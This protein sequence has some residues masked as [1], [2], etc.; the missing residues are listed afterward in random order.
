MDHLSLYQFGIENV[1]A[2]SGTALTIQQAKLLRRYVEHTVL[3]FDGD[4]AGMAAAVRGIAPLI[5]TGIDVRVVSL[6]NGQDPDTFIREQGKEALLGVIEDSLPLVDFLVT[7]VGTLEDLTTSDGKARATHHIAD[8]IGRVTDATLRQFLIRDTAERIGIEEGV[9]IQSVKDAQKSPR[10][11]RRE[12]P[13][14]TTVS[15]ADKFDP[16][17]WKERELLIQM[18]SDVTIA[19]LVLKQIQPEDF[20][21]SVYRQFA[22]IIATQRNNGW[23]SSVAHIVD[24]LTD[25]GL[26][27]I[28]SSLSLET[29]ITN[30][31]QVE[32][33]V[34]DYINDIHLRKMDRQ[35]DELNVRM[36]NASVEELTELMQIH[37]Q[38]T[39][40]R[41]MIKESGSFPSAPLTTIADAATQIVGREQG[42][43]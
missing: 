15:A 10:P 17:Q 36:R 7:W 22:Q 14:E 40:D 2:T 27:R 24:C 25:D 23:G 11:Q 41:R 9:V 38:M 1:V 33:P 26:A 12:A 30:P 16:G 35:I 29:G 3:I 20:E 19:D 4:K 13:R 34:Q 28:V 6:P 37:K 39:L 8:L 5:E 43:P 18:M 32:L 31:D 21:N 42:I